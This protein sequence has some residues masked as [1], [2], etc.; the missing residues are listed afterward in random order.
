[1]GPISRFGPVASLGLLVFRPKLPYF[2]IFGR[3]T[4][5]HRCVVHLEPSMKTTLLGL[6]VRF[7]PTI[8]AFFVVLVLGLCS[9]FLGLCSKYIFSG[10]IRSRMVYLARS[11]YLSKV[12]KYS[13]VVRIFMGESRGFALVYFGCAHSFLVQFLV[14]FLGKRR[15]V[16]Q[17]SEPF[18]WVYSTF[19]EFIFLHL[20]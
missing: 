13:H 2:W 20:S 14:Q 5:G 11:A 10:T 17:D 6:S 3:N 8:F 9:R 16:K 7:A 4:V 12:P 15:V 18:F 1:M 19:L